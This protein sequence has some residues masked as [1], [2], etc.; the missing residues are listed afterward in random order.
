MERV[1]QLQAHQV[2]VRV[3]SAV[4]H[5][6]ADCGLIADHLIECELRGSSDGG[7]ARTVSILVPGRSGFMNL[8]GA[9]ESCEGSAIRC[10]RSAGRLSVA[11][12]DTS[13]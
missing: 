9:R 7:P 10:G 2:A 11:P 4:G 3:M 5:D 13:I 1:M 6:E 8:T 12:W